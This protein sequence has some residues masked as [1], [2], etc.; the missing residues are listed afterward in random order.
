M[1]PALAPLPLGT[2]SAPAQELRSFPSWPHFSEDEIA[3]AVEVLRSGRVNYWSGEHVRK[4]EQ[5]FAATCGCKH[6]VAVANGT[7]ALELALRSVGIGLGD[8]VIVPS[9]TFVASASC[10]VMCG[11]RPVFADID[12]ESQN[13]TAATIEAALTPA[14]RAI[15]AVHLA[16]WP[17]DMD[18]ILELTRRKNL[19]VIEDCAQAQGATYH[20]LLVGSFGDAAAFSFCQDKIMTTAGEGGMLVTN[21]SS[22]FERAWAL[23][24]HGKDYFEAHAQRQN[25]TFRWLHKVPGT[26]A[27]MTEIQA[28]VGRRQLAKVPVWLEMRRQNAYMLATRLSQLPALR[29]PF[30]PK[31]TCHAFYRLYAF[32]RSE[33]LKPNWTRDRLIQAIAAQGVPCSS[34]SCGEVYL[35]QAFANFRP[36]ERLPVARELA[37]TSLAFLVHPTLDKTDMGRICDVVETVI[38]EA[39]LSN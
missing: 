7:V 36:P 21:H 5:E 29:I 20:G 31:H 25:G 33:R 4:F 9:R 38:S 15:I 30:P 12:G 35:E 2:Q 1:I 39:T 18:S 26:N 11:A 3:A 17:C 13:V 27:R 22:L 19:L 23:K 14:T 32:V 28:A 37:E 8:D 24:D 10:V 34:G 16:G 6:A